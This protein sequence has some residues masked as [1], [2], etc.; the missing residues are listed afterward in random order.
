MVNILKGNYNYLKW[1]SPTTLR[2]YFEKQC[3]E[4]WIELRDFKF[5][6]EF[7]E[8]SQEYSKRNG[9]IVILKRLS[10]GLFIKLTNDA[11]YSSYDEKNINENSFNGQ[12]LDFGP[13]S[14]FIDGE[15]F[16]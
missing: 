7:D 10:D 14:N 12:W 3:A 9:L 15:V 6:A 13:N 11:F 2:S 5:I 8:I 16:I 1:G 4:K